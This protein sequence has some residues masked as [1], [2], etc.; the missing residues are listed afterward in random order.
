[1]ASSSRNDDTTETPSRE[2]GF[3]D[4]TCN[5]DELSYPATT[6]CTAATGNGPLKTTTRVPALGFGLYKVPSGEEGVRIVSDAILRAGY[7][8]L[9]SASI[10]GNEKTVGRALEACCRGTKGILSAAPCD[11]E[12]TTTT[13]T[14]A[15]SL[16]D[17]LPDPKLLGLFTVGAFVMRGAGCTINDLWDRDLDREVARTKTRPLAAWILTPFQAMIWLGLQLS[18]GLGVLLSLP[19]TEYC[20]G[21]GVASLPIVV[22]YPLM[23]RFFDYP[24]LVLGL[25]FNW[26][27]F[28]GWAAVHGGV[29]YSVVLPLY[30]SGVAWT[31]GYDTLYAHQDKE[32]DA[33]L[34]LKSTAITFGRLGGGSGSQE[35]NDSNDKRVLYGLAATT[36]AC[37]LVAGYHD[38]VPV[39]EVAT[40]TRTSPP[41]SALLP[42]GAYTT[43]VTGACAHLLWQIR[44]ADLSDPHN[45]AERFRSNAK[46]GGIVFGSILAGKLAMVL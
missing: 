1:M 3:G 43:G 17:V 9:D 33:K 45:L 44:T 8:H 29:D 21:W 19:N 26:G 18:V 16:V 37:W 4:A 38:F 40:T 6:T 7:R 27:A 25:C 31:I 13:T 41:S 32:D 10:Y 28:M 24:Q 35:D 46:V 23:K 42:F 5:N 15:L 11:P 34:G 20:F 22:A 39:A 36:Y 12:I 14:T 30:A 2:C